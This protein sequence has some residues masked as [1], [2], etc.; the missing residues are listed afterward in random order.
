M[1]TIS[2]AW[3]FFQNQILGMKWLNELIGRA[4]AAAGLDNPILHDTDL[5]I[6]IAV[7]GIMN[8]ILKDRKSSV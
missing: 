7:G 4:L 6:R 3:L 1:E 2:T 8:L 5:A